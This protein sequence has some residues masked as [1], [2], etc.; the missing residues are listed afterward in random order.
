MVDDGKERRYSG[1]LGYHQQMRRI[2]VQLYHSVS[3]TQLAAHLPSKSEPG[4]V[5]RA[6][7]S[8]LPVVDCE[9]VLGEEELDPV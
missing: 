8:L 7:A 6:V 4:Q 1:S 5:V 2:A 9:S 3:Q